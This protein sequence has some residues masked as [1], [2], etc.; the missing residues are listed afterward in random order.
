MGDGPMLFKSAH[1]LEKGVK[2]ALLGSSDCYP[3]VDDEILAG[4]ELRV[5]AGQP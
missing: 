1:L 4:G 3:A 2:F 5:I